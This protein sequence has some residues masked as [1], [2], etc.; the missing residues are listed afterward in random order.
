MVATNRNSFSVGIQSTMYKEYVLIDMSC[1][2]TSLMCLI[3]LIM[4]SPHIPHLCKRVKKKRQEQELAPR[5]ILFL[6]LNPTRPTY[7]HLHISSSF[8]PLIPLVN[9]LLVISSS[10]FIYRKPALYPIYCSFFFFSLS[11]SLLFF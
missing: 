7:P 10:K 6:L 3:I 5:L 11:I 2:D 4:K 9:R 8:R 1:R